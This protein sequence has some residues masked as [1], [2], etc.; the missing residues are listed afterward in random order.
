MDNR[1]LEELLKNIQAMIKCPHCGSSY[2]KEN[3][4]IV[5]NMGEAVL[6]QLACISC[7]MPVMATIVAKGATPYVGLSAKPNMISQPINNM[8]GSEK[9]ISSDE[10]IDMHNFLAS[11]NGDFESIFKR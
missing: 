2:T 7:K 10:I 5:G 1:N 6:V 8:L 11:F 9:E 3:I 4:S